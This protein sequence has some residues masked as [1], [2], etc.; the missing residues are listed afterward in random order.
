VISESEIEFQI[1]SSNAHLNI[2]EDNNEFEESSE[3]YF[4]LNFKRSILDRKLYFT[5]GLS[6]HRFVWKAKNRNNRIA[7]FTEIRIPVNIEARTE[8]EII[9]IRAY[10]GFNITGLFTN[11]DTNGYVSYNL[12]GSVGLNL[13]N[14][15]NIGV[16]LN[17]VFR[18]RALQNRDNNFEYKVLNEYTIGFFV[19]KKL[20]FY[21]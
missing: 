7:G 15:T 16:N 12:G 3:S 2:V 13:M 9:D 19:R 11:I 21:E 17:R 8:L 6:R 10:T 4:Q 20:F 1:G 18:H 14:G 5:S